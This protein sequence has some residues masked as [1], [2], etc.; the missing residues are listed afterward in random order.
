M[1]RLQSANGYVSPFVAPDASANV[2][3]IRVALLLHVAKRLGWLRRADDD[4]VR[5]TGN[6]V[7]AFLEQPRPE[8]RFTLWEAWRTS[9]EWKRL[10]AH[11]RPRLFVGRLAKQSPANT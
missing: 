11:T 10:G 3:E 8:Q 4:R 5:L 7:Y 1:M 2:E 6:R 9:P